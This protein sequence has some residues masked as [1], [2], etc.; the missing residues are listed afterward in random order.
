TAWLPYRLNRALW[1]VATC[2]GLAWCVR[3]WSR[4]GGDATE[5]WLGP[6]SVPLVVSGSD[7][8]RDMAERGLQLALLCLVTA[9]LVALV[10]GRA[11]WCGMW[12]GL[13]TVYKVMPLVFLPYLVWKRQWKAALSMAAAVCVFSLLPGLYLGWQTNLQLHN[14]WLV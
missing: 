11:A 8:L 7:I 12:L 14:Q 9:A 13:A 10:R 5:R 4:V 2:V 1:L 3:F 6:A